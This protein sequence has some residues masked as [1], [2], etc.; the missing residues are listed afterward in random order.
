MRLS[1]PGIQ[2]EPLSTS[3][4]VLPGLSP[5][6][7]HLQ[8]GGH[9]L[10]WTDHPRG[11]IPRPPV[12]LLAFLEAPHS[13]SGFLSPGRSLGK[14]NSRDP[15]PVICVALCLELGKAESAC[16]GAVTSVSLASPR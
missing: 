5:D 15:S 16:V 2:P 9:S 1:G 6:S 13:L 10:L 8:G 12:S 11:A 3:A 4:F 14:I 7:R